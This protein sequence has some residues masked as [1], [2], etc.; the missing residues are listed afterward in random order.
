MYN[1][2]NLKNIKG[3]VLIKITE[4]Q[5]VQLVEQ[6]L[7]LVLLVNPTDLLVLYVNKQGA[8]ELGILPDDL[9]GKNV[10]ELLPDLTE[11][12][13]GAIFEGVMHSETG[14][15]LV[16]S[17]KDLLNFEHDFEFKLK[18]VNID[19]ADYLLANGRDVSERMAL[20]DQI[21][22]L[23]AVAQTELQAKGKD[24]K[25][26]LLDTE[27]FLTE[28][29]KLASSLGSANLGRLTLLVLEIKNLVNINQ[30]YGHNIGDKVLAHISK[31]LVHLVGSEAISGRYS[32]RKL[33]VILPNKGMQDGLML[34]EKLTRA[35]SKLAYKEYASLRV[36]TSIGAG[37]IPQSAAADL[38]MNKAIENL[39]KANTN[40]SH[41][42]H[43]LG[44][45]AV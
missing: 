34:A 17:V 23:L 30:D 29:N 1:Y 2:L 3:N 13:L 10:L 7:D 37:E 19:G 22:E 45:L 35:F 42:I 31:L 26:G 12:E 20:N 32:G 5:L 27:A 15:T 14:E 16:T 25:T 11:V 39:S 8:E 4:Q 38:I 41:E 18:K 40:V 24:S 6:S 21:Q 43:R 36:Q 28:L 44:L 33:A 9:I